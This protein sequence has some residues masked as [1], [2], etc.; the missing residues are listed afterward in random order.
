MSSDEEWA[1][2]TSRIMS[3]DEKSS[4]ATPASR[5]QRASASSAAS[6]SSDRFLKSLLSLEPDAY[7]EIF[8]DILVA[9][10]QDVKTLV[11][12]IPVTRSK[13]VAFNR[14]LRLTVYGLICQIDDENFRYKFAPR[15]RDAPVADL[16]SV[17]FDY[18]DRPYGKREWSD[19]VVYN[20]L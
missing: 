2:A 15:M 14:E 19:L 16:P 3:S 6:W 8:L 5:T 4:A 10:L 20:N 1:V 13:D 18:V 11:D 17:D 12:V 9:K 7:H